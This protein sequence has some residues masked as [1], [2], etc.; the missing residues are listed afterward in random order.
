VEIVEEEALLVRDDFVGTLECRTQSRGGLLSGRAK[1]RDTA[2]SEKLISRERLQPLLGDLTRV[3]EDGALIA[4]ERHVKYV[5]VDG[6]ERGHGFSE[7]QR[8]GAT[9][10]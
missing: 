3:R 9:H 1:P 8:K 5:G 10:R 6:A 2:V 4:R 7:P